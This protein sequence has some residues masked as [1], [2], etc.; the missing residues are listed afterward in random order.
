MSLFQEGPAI[1]EEPNLPRASYFLKNIALMITTKC[2]VNCR[3]C[4][5]HR[6]HFTR[7]D[8][9]LPTILEWIE[10]ISAYDQGSIKMIYLT[11][12]EPFYDLENLRTISSY[13][14]SRGLS[15]SVI[16]NGMW[17]K[18]QKQAIAI[19]QQLPSIKMVAI[20]T[21]AYHQDYIPIKN[22]INVIEAAKQCE[23]IYVV[24]VC[25]ED[26]EDAVY[27]ETVTSLEKKV[28]REFINTMIT[29]PF[30]EKNDTTDKP[31]YQYTVEPDR[32]PC[33][34]INFPAITVDGTVL[35]CCGGL[36]AI[37]GNHPL[38]LGNMDNEPLSGILK[39][40]DMNPILHAL[41]IWG[42][43]IFISYIKNAKLDDGL[44]EKYRVNCPC[45]VC[46]HLLS[47]PPIVKY[48]FELAEDEE[49]CRKVAYGRVYYFGES[50][51]AEKYQSTE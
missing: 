10:Q 19:L 1:N 28:K 7:T 14:E 44:P 21:D 8:T 41:R 39:K 2:Q 12:G 26:T 3:H 17:A 6:G 31:D 46:Y 23:K 30:G 49:F 51:M 16:T 15:V 38:I 35:A 50:R 36:L 5:V 33:F 18:S 42:P 24:N 47:S 13:A 40:A 43:A 4:I 27:K 37:N 45:D 34:M 22:V 11:G 20:S 25:T 48:L 9:S 32:F 29:I